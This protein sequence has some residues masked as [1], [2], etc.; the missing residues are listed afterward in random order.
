VLEKL[1]GTC[2]KPSLKDRNNAT[3]TIMH[4]ANDNANRALMCNDEI[5]EALIHG[6][7]ASMDPTNVGHLATKQTPGVDQEALLAEMQDSALRA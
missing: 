6:V 4:L 1:A 5:L 2:F 3:R 7:S